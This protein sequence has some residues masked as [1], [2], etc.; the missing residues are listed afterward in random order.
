MLEISF[1][2]QS[3][4]FILI[5]IFFHSENIEFSSKILFP[6]EIIKNLIQRLFKQIFQNKTTIAI[7]YLEHEIIKKLF[8]FEKNLNK[9]QV[10]PF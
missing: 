2:N 4:D 3:H 8:I 9:N 10:S 1:L 6:F 7:Y 5:I